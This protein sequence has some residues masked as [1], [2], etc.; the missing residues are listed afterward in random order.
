MVLEMGRVVLLMLLLQVLLVLLVLLV[1]LLL[2]IKLPRSWAVEV[3][4][5]PPPSIV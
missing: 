2:G 3:V 5:P 4:N 1:M